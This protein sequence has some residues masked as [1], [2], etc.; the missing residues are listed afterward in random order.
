MRVTR[1]G[2]EFRPITLIFG[3][4]DEGVRETQVLHGLL[5]EHVSNRTHH[6]FDL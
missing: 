2:E 6:V 3:A 4:D 1:R 5:V